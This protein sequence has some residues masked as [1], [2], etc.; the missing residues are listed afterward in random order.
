MKTAPGEPVDEKA[1]MFNEENS[2]VF[3]DHA[4]IKGKLT[5]GNESIEVSVLNGGSIAGVPFKGWN[6]DKLSKINI[7]DQKMNA[8]ILDQYLLDVYTVY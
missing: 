6:P 1:F 2:H 3:L 7:V 4:V 5:N 8:Q